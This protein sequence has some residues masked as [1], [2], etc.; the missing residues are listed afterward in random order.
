MTH[1]W[2]FRTDSGHHGWCH[3]CRQLLQRDREGNYRRG[4][5]CITISM[6][7]GYLH[8]HDYCINN[9]IGEILEKIQDED[10]RRII[11]QTQQAFQ[12]ERETETITEDGGLYD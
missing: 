2:T 11:R 6:S 7:R 3:H 12:T 8:M 10:T 4:G 9:F 1:M 5:I